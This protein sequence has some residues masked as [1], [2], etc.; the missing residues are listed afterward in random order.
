[1][2][3]VLLIGIIAL[4]IVYVSSFLVGNVLCGILKRRKTFGRSVVYGFI[5][6]VFIF[7]IEGLLCI[8]LIQKFS[9][10]Y[11]SFLITAILIILY[12]AAYF[13]YHKDIYIYI[14]PYIR[15]YY[16]MKQK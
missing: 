4:L 9:I 14:Y 3:R 13:V 12:S 11:Y 7:Q 5:L 16:A 8:A 10:L 15:I 1:M 2:I 6:W